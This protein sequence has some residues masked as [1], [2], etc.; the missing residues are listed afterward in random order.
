LYRNEGQFT[1][2]N[3]CVYRTMHSFQYTALVVSTAIV[4]TALYRTM[5]IV[6]LP[7]HS[8][9][10][11][12][13]HSVIYS[14]VQNYVQLSGYSTCGKY[15]HSV[16][17]TV[18]NYVHSYQDTALVVS[19]TIVYYTALCITMYSYQNTTL[20]VSTAIV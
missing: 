13:S 4:Y 3:D 17:S 18:Q 12:Y 6:Q 11:K 7:V 14:A 5:Y 15:S 2:L 8:T 19:T 9:C 1:A 20:V 10:G 16:Y